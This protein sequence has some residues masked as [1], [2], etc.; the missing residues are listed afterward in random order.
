MLQDIMLANRMFHH[1]GGKTMLVG[2]SIEPEL[3]KREDVRKDM[4]VYTAIFARESITYEALKAA[5]IQTDVYLIPDSTFTLEAKIL[6][7]PEGFQTGNTVGIN[8]SPM[9]IESETEAGITLKNYQNLVQYILEKTDMSVVLIPHVVWERNDDRKAIAKLYEDFVDNPRVL[10]IGDRSCEEL[11]GFIKHCRFFIGART[12]ATIAAYSTQVPTLVVGYSVKAKGIAKD[13][14]GTYEKYVLPVQELK[15]EEQLIEA[16]QWLM[17]QEQDIIRQYNVIMPAY[18]RQ[19][20]KL[21]EI[22]TRIM[23]KE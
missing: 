9:I 14:F 16:F 21:G 18:I 19:A 2:C 22:M 12:H 1:N 20:R 5:N 15:Q 11:K 23:N 6:P 17:G 3:L 7:L 10:A 13:L 8:I 4:A